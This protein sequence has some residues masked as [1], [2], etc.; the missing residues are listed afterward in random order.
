VGLGTI[1]YLLYSKLFVK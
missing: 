1:V